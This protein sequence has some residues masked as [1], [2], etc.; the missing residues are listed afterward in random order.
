MSEWA[1]DLPEW[2]TQ[3]EISVLILSLKLKLPNEVKLSK[4]VLCCI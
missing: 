2:A 1:S 3:I 4:I